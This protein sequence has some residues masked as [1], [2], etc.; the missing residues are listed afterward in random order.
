[1][2]AKPVVKN[3]FWIVENEG[4]KVATI[5]RCDQG[6]TWVCD[7]GRQKFDSF[8]LLKNQYPVNI[9]KW[10]PQKSVVDSHSVY[11]YPCDSLPFNT[12][13]DIKHKVPLFTK[14][15]KSRCY[16]A[17]GYY[18]MDGEIVFCPK[19]IFINRISFTGPYLTRQEAE[20]YT[21]G[22]ITTNNP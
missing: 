7:D 2:I 16:Y 21:N 13:W 9:G 19:Y 5:Q 8:D 10:I 18:V 14:S 15:K 12:V 17:A 22:T 6:V 1:M 4:K 3:K 11:K 20:L